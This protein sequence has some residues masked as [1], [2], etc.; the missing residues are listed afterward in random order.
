MSGY[1]SPKYMRGEHH[2]NCVCKHKR[3][4][5]GQISGLVTTTK[6]VMQAHSRNQTKALSVV[7]MQSSDVSFQNSLE[8][9][10]K[11]RSRERNHGTLTYGCHLAPLN[12]TREK[13]VEGRAKVNFRSHQVKEKPVDMIEK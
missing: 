2:A 4:G 1:E 10:G 6:H 13:G 11:V 5:R 12:Q 8:V 3:R 9:G 7:K